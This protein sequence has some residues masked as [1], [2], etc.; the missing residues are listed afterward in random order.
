MNIFQG[1]DTLV[2]SGGGT[3]GLAFCGV[4]EELDQYFSIQKSIKTFR[5]CSIGAL[6]SFLL[7]VGMQGDE[8][9]QIFELIDW[10]KVISLQSMVKG[11]FQNGALGVIDSSNFEKMLE[12]LIFSRWPT[13]PNP[14]LLNFRC[15]YSLTKR[16]LQM[17]ATEF[18][19]GKVVTFDHN[20]T[21]EVS[22]IDALVASMSIPWLLPPRKIGDKYY[23]DGGLIVNYPIQECPTQSTIGI[24]LI[25]KRGI[26][27]MLGSWSSYSWGV[28]HLPS[29]VYEEKMMSRLPSKLRERTIIVNTGSDFSTFDF[30]L[31]GD[32]M[33]EILHLGRM[34]FRAWFTK[35]EDNERAADTDTSPIY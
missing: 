10:Y 4:L 9:H 28:L 12:Q 13:L 1:I 22:V 7:V 14:R 2:L 17:I 5:G 32:R 26:E 33:S 34:A 29:Q 6:F 20:E 31:V 27:Q 8:I 25:Q 24:R 23:L 11:F 19:T 35:I 18:E 3:R 16:N 30:S 15:M 21:P